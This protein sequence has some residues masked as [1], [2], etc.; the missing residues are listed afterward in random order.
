V[1]LKVT[2]NNKATILVYVPLTP[3]ERIDKE[4]IYF[5]VDTPDITIGQWHT[6]QEHTTHFNAKHKKSTKVFNT[7]FVITI[8]ATITNLNTQ[9]ATL[10]FFYY[11]QS[12]GS[13]KHHCL[14][15]PI[16]AQTIPKNAT[17]SPDYP[18]SNNQVDQQQGPIKNATTS[19]SWMHRHLPWQLLLF[20][21]TTT[22]LYVGYFCFNRGQKIQ[23]TIA[24]ALY[25][26]VGFIAISTGVVAAGYALKLWYS[27]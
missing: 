5:S 27:L 22:L 14:R 17:I 4:S 7:S 19:T 15:L 8:P 1:R 11:H 23:S 10:H 3:G 20:L 26:I 21:L 24:R 25:N 9:K 16:R 13:M 6:Q 12:H 2:S 18:A